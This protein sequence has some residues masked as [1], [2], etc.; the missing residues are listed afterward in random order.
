MWPR[1]RHGARRQG[2]PEFPL[3]PFMTA[4]DLIEHSKL[5]PEAALE[6]AA[7]EGDRPK[8]HPGLM[9]FT[10][11]AVLQYL[12][13]APAMATAPGCAVMEPS[14][15][16]WVYLWTGTP[17]GGGR[18]VY[19]ITAWGRRYRSPDGRVRELRI[20]RLGSAGESDRDP[21]EVAV[22]AYVA[23]LGVPAVRPQR[24]SDPYRARACAQ[25]PERVRVVQYGCADGSQQVLFDG[26]AAEAETRFLD[27]G[28]P[29][30]REAVS[31]T[32]ERPGEGCATCKLISVCTALP[33]LPGLLGITVA[34]QPVRTWSV[35]NGRDYEACPTK[36]H[37]RRLHL[38]RTG[39]YDQPARR[40]KAVHARIEELHSRNPA[41]PCTSQDL[42]ADPEQWQ[43]IWKLDEEQA[44]LG[45][46][47]LG[48]H[49]LVCPFA[50][51]MVIGKVR[52]ELTLTVYDPLAG[53]IVLAKPDLLYQDRGAWVWRETKTG[54]R[55]RSRL[56]DVL[57][58]YPQTALAVV[59]LAAGALGG[60]ADGSRV[61]LEILRPDGPDIYLLDPGDPAT[62]RH[63]TDVVRD[64]A[65]PWHGDLQ[66]DPR[67]GPWCDRCEVARWCPAR[68]QTCGRDAA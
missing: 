15:D 43:D 61:E 12:E 67:P 2:R 64:L 35:T 11:D 14:A 26:T 28:S 66:L 1:E 16:E 23:A 22:A 63:A 53:V 68:Y 37:L 27:L 50:N 32:A 13:A 24:W 10:R 52:P 33:R 60:A 25:R 44:V 31:G 19:E 5:T 30:L 7:R 62:A 40:G 47:Q 6:L 18:S 38:P 54:G 36:D 8:A 20:P 3:G 49:L 48:W 4:L 46:R 45:T 42:R 51:G 29:R 58:S 39:E 65:A 21:A 59:L 17:P 34:G 41:R 56:T 55:I 9:K 57:R